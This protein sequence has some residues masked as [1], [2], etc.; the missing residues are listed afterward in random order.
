MLARSLKVAW[1]D[2]QPVY[3][4]SAKAKMVSNPTAVLQK[5]LSVQRE[6]IDSRLAVSSIS[7][8]ITLYLFC[9]VNLF[10][11]W[12]FCRGW[13]RSGDVG[14]SHRLKAILFCTWGR[15][16]S[17]EEHQG[18]PGSTAL[19]LHLPA[20]LLRTGGVCALS[21]LP[22]RQAIPSHASAH[23]NGAVWTVI[24]KVLL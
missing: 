15:E 1:T 11:G 8:A 22:D 18:V 7:G 10:Q 2:K 19:S 21:C 6:T 20:R 5:S 9:K 4:C 12:M 16:R 23:P 3:L 17:G 13:D 24:Y 14:L